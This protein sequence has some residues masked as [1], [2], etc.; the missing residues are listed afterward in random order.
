MKTKLF[1]LITFISINCF[2]Q[3]IQDFKLY[4]NPCVDKITFQFKVNHD[5]TI[6]LS[7]VDLTGKICNKFYIKD[8]LKS[9][10]YKIDYT[11]NS[12]K[13]GIYMAMLESTDKK[14]ISKFIKTGNIDSAKLIDFTKITYI[15]SIKIYD[16]IKVYVFDTTKVLIIDTLKC[17]ATISPSL[18]DY[19]RIS[20]S[21]SI[22][23]QD[24]LIINSSNVDYIEIYDM[25]G[26]NM[27]K[28]I[29]HGDVSLSDFK[30]GFYIGLFYQHNNLVSTIKILKK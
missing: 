17:N 30:S 27:R 20:V 23:V 6:S 26:K 29:V 2:S 25:S 24:D 8:F 9:G 11:A 15:D 28:T 13:S 22:I 16:S 19:K 1:L 3:T 14:M 4:P 7:T 12:L 18:K 10:T 5:D 21:E